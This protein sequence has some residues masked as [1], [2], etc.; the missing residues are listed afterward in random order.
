MVCPSNI[1]DYTHKC[2]PI[3]ETKYELNK[4][5]TNKHVKLHR[6]KPWSLNPTQRNTG[7]L[8]MLGMWECYSSYKRN[9]EVWAVSLRQVIQSCSCSSNGNS[10]SQHSDVSLCGQQEPGQARTNRDKDVNQDPKS[11]MRGT[12]STSN[13]KQ[14]FNFG[15]LIKWLPENR[16]V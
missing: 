6:E 11:T 15:L 13:Q 3:W 1:R 10:I 2:S 9:K 14:S 4:E 7:K 8:G 12:E 16:P 5:D